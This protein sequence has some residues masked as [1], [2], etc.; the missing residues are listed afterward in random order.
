LNPPFPVTNTILRH[1]HMN[2]HFRHRSASNSGIASTGSVGQLPPAGPAPLPPPKPPRPYG[3][4]SSGG[5]PLSISTVLKGYESIPY[6]TS[7]IKNGQGPS[8]STEP[9]PTLSGQRLIPSGTPEGS[10][11]PSSIQL[12]GGT[13]T[14][15]VEGQLSAADGPASIDS[16]STVT[17]TSS[18]GSNSTIT[19]VPLEIY[20]V[21]LFKDRDY[22]D[23]GFSVSD[24]A[25]N[26]GVYINK[27]RSGG[28]ADLSGFVKPFDKLIQ[29]NN[30]S[31]RDLDCLLAVPLLI[32]AS[33]RV[34]LYICRDPTTRVR[35]E[36]IEEEGIDESN[37]FTHDGTGMEAT[38]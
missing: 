38:C 2:G 31:L 19:N 8:T 17:F 33:D 3:A 13:L 16:N 23:F 26:K 4:P 1:P 35:P 7:P 5:T 22:N 28:P 36:S 25:T 18:N 32:S 20:R 21:T 34:D 37:G 14:P 30:T 12:S 9:L 27:V 15:S 11:T 24:G 10:S 29:V 6:I